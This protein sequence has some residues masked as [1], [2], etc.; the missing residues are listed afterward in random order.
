MIHHITIDQLKGI[1]M[2]DGLILRGCGSEPTDWQ[3]G[4]NELLTDAD[5]LK[6]GGEFKDIYVFKDEELTNILYPFDDMTPDKLDIGKL[7]M[8][9][10][11][12]HDNFAGI[13]YS[14]YLDNMPNIDSME[15]ADADIESNNGIEDSEVMDDSESS[16]H[17]ITIYIENAY[18][19]N[20][21]S[22]EIPLPTTKKEIQPLLEDTGIE[23]LRDIRIDAV[24]SDM[25]GVG[26]RLQ[27][28]I[29]DNGTTPDTLDEL[30]YLATRIRDLVV[31]DD[32][33]GKIIFLANIEAGL[34][35]SSIKEVINITF[36][37]NINCYEILPFFSLEDYGEYLVTQHLQDKHAEAFTRLND[38]KNP[39][40]HALVAHIEKLEKHTNYEAFGMTTAEEENG[41]TT[42]QG[43]LLGSESFQQ[44]YH[45][46]QDIP[47]NCCLL[48]SEED[49][50]RFMKIDNVNIAETIV[51]LHAVGCR[52][53]E[54]VA[55][56]V[57]SFLDEHKR[58][59]EGLNRNFLANHYI[60]VLNSQSVSI[61]PMTEICKQ[62]SEMFKFTLDMSRKA[63]QNRPDIRIFAIRVNN[64]NDEVAGQNA[65]GGFIELSPKAL[66]SYI[67]HNAISPNS[68][69]ILRDDGTKNLYDLYAWGL[70][71][72][73][74]GNSVDYVLNYSNHEMSGAIATLGG[75][76]GDYEL[77]SHAESFE[78][79]LPRI[80]NPYKQSM[81]E[82]ETPHPYNDMIR[83]D[84]ESAKEILASENAE[85]YN[86][87]DDKVTK[88]NIF[89]FLR[90]S[91]FSEY[92]NL[93]IKHSDAKILDKWAERK[94][95][96]IVQQIERGELSKS[97]GKEERE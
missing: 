80:S 95:G 31:N 17:P 24:H 13:W 12:E 55:D 4:I 14:D 61:A 40:D 65:R 68:A 32:E 15:V 51:K 75:F 66:N 23:N 76:I 44:F 71:L 36:K 63:E 29:S 93:A 94:V 3:N 81:A 8:W 83:I 89:E 18:E 97:S 86:L 52:N 73:Q 10:L 5:I 42:E 21:N 11:Q 77:T 30:N 33:Y 57:K 72:Q 9:R 91:S 41:I 64:G 88:V 78:F 6:N 37:E 54:Y 67:T 34:N 45:G 38:S 2:G 7:T 92:S 79:H 43:Y 74:R 69:Y 39:Q 48:K 84:K 62:D 47:T 85:V 1:T 96:E 70:E 27:Q 28:I 50:E 46:V 58:F 49:V 16:I 60:L 53:M 56:N 20:D 25:P 26:E 35:C 19:S 87:A 82:S 22:F 90:P 59:A